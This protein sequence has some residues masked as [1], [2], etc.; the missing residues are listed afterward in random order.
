[1]NIYIGN[2]PYKTGD[3]ELRELFEEYGEVSDANIIF[4]RRT[5]RSRG[6]GFVEMTNDN[7]AQKAID[8]LNGTEFGERTLKVAE[9]NPRDESRPRHNNSDPQGSNGNKQEKSGGGMFGF[10]KK[11]FG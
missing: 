4:D 11:L 9:A 10:I 8:N 3:S 5:R 1:M 7:E 2:L 6:Y